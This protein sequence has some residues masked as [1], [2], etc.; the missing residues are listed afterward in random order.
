M[1][2]DSRL[3]FRGSSAFKER[4][5]T[6]GWREKNIRKGLWSTSSRCSRISWWPLSCR[7]GCPWEG[8]G[9]A[10][11][12]EPFALWADV[13]HEGTYLRPLQGFLPPRHPTRLPKPC[14]RRGPQHTGVSSSGAA[15]RAPPAYLPPVEPSADPGWTS[16]S[17]PR[18]AAEPWLYSGSTLSGLVGCL[19]AHLLSP[20]QGWLSD[21]VSPW[22]RWNVGLTWQD[23]GAQK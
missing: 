4:R 20:A 1:C 7:C 23:S 14:L 18:G 3:P 15:F 8:G 5:K 9:G 12:C 10:S 16:S 13:I 11:R 17:S 19:S 22:C 2:A 6:F 21:S